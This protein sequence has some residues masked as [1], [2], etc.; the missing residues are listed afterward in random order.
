[1]PKQLVVFANG[2][3]FRNCNYNWN[4]IAKV[5][6][7]SMKSSKGFKS[8]KRSIGLE[9]LVGSIS[10]VSLVGSKVYVEK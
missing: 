7:N 5:K 2:V 3:I 8:S 9:G 4:H 1:M 10:W 6:F